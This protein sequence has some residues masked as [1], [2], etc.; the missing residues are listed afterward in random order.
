MNKKE[1]VTLLKNDGID[2][3]EDMA[4]VAVRAAINIVRV[5]VPKLS[6]GAGTMLNLF[7]NA[8]ED[9]I[10]KLLDKIDGKT[11]LE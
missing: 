7:L 9:D 8:Y 3:G 10:Y 1:I 5:I 6:R 11:D 4:I 2:L